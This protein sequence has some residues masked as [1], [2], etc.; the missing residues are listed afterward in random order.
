VLQAGMDLSA[1]AQDFP[2][3]APLPIIT[4]GQREPLRVPR[5]EHAYLLP[6]GARLP[7]TPRGEVFDIR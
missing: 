1:R 7:F 3:E 4:D 2:P 6:R 5:R